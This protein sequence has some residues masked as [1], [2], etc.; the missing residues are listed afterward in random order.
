MQ[1]NFLFNKNV[2]TIFGILYILRNA[3]H[4]NVMNLW[5][6]MHITIISEWMDERMT[7]RLMKMASHMKY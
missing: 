3:S 5:K 4:I 6:E 1:A 2:Y 7:G